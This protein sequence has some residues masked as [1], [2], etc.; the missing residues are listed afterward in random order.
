MTT[1]NYKTI[2]LLVTM[3]VFAFALQ[4]QEYRPFE[5]STP[6][7]NFQ[8]QKPFEEFEQH[9]IYEQNE[10]I[11][12]DNKNDEVKIRMYENRNPGG[13]VSSN[14]PDDPEDTP[15]DGGLTLLV[16]AGAA[17]GV[18]RYRGQRKPDTGN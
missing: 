12:S 14:A 11:Q 1:H 4:A 9:S 15:I 5:E 2:G 8:E 17:Y 7:N 18:K 10:S 13:W 6:E 3:M 16:A